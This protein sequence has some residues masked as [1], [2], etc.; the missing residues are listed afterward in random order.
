MI[1]ELLTQ[2]NNRVNALRRVSLSSEGRLSQTLQEL[3]G[4]VQAIEARQ[5]EEAQRLSNAHVVRAAEVVR[6][7]FQDKD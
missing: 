1:G 3:D 4:V 5:P 6:A 7:S 2:L